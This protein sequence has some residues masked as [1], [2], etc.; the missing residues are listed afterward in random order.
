MVQVDAAD[1]LQLEGSLL[2]NRDQ[3]LE[4]YLGQTIYGY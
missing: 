2:V 4:K 1:K 3:N